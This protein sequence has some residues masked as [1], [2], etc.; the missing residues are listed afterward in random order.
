PI[1][2]AVDGIAKGTTYDEAERDRS[3]SGGRAREPDPQQHDR[4]GLEREQRPLAQWALLRKEA[5][6]DPRIAGEDE[7]EEGQKRDPAARG[8]IGPEDDPELAGLI[9]CGCGNRHSKAEAAKRPPQHG[10]IWSCGHSAAL[11]M[12]SHSRSAWASRGE[13]SG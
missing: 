1:S 7:I 5:V 9:D 10:P 12:I 6:A 13:T 2:Q 3:E 8:E 11:R 4:N